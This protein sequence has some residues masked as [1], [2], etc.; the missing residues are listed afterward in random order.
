[1]GSRE[2]VDRARRRRLAAVLATVC[3]GLQAV[4]IVSPATA[5]AASFDVDNMNDAVDVNPGDGLCVDTDGACSLRA[6]LMELNALGGANHTINIVKA[7]D[8]P[9]QVPLV[10]NDTGADSDASGDLDVATDVIITVGPR[11]EAD[12]VPGLGFNDRAFNVLPGGSLRLINVNVRGFDS[13]VDGGAIYNQGTMI[14]SCGTHVENNVGRDGG[15]IYNAGLLHFV[16]ASSIAN[17]T[18]RNGGGLYAAPGSTSSVQGNNGAC[19]PNPAVRMG[20][21]IAERGSAIYADGAQVN[22]NHDVSVIDATATTSGGAFEVVNDAEIRMTNGTLTVDNASAPVGGVAHVTNSGNFVLNPSGA[23]SEVRGIITD[24]TS[25]AGSAHFHGEVGDVELVRTVVQGGSGDAILLEGDSVL[26]GYELAV[27]AGQPGDDG[28][29]LGGPR[30]SRLRNSYIDGR[31]TALALTDTAGVDVIFTTITGNDVGVDPAAGT[32]FD[33]DAAW[34]FGNSVNC[35]ATADSMLET[36]VSD[37]SCGTAGGS[38]TD[39]SAASGVQDYNYSATPY[40]GPGPSSPILGLVSS[41]CALGSDIGAQP[42]PGSNGDCEPGAVEFA[43]SDPDPDPDPEGP[44]ISGSVVEDETLQPLAGICVVAF[45]DADEVASFDRTED[46]GDWLLAGLEAGDYRLVFFPCDGEGEFDESSPIVPE[47]WQNHAV[48]TESEN[49]AEDGDPI[50]VDSADSDVEAADVSGID[51]C[52]GTDP[53]GGDETCGV[54]PDTPVTTAPTTTAPPETAP[55]GSTDDGTTT[56]S[57]P[58]AAQASNT[59]AAGATP[60]AITG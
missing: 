29:T 45:D 8:D 39:G 27:R 38:I 11:S 31:A 25:G 15:A 49:P 13:G 17:N 1:M 4:W 5:G 46:D 30:T 34:I 3:L 54:T 60:L 51:A 57:V 47:S 21:S 56:T 53:D 9:A 16:G 40:V 37:S 26:E 14:L 19:A 23:G 33:L 43:G 50:T 42:R 59:P 28:I 48:D 52:L 32:S 24:A 2:V 6:A 20:E 10:I 12:I 18:A 22:I 35:T 36:A 58:G 44:S 41:P 55:T 7:V